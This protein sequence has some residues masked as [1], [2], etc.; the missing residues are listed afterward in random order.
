MAEITVSLAPGSSSQPFAVVRPP[1]R[2]RLHV[3][4]EDGNENRAMIVVS[5]L[6]NVLVATAKTVTARREKFGEDSGPEERILCTGH[7]R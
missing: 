2:F 6:A 5:F 7:R 1:E 4:A 3:H